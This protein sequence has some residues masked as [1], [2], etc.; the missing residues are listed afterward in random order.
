MYRDNMLVLLETK[1]H[2]VVAAWQELADCV[3]VHLVTHLPTWSTWW[4]GGHDVDGGDD[5][6]EDQNDQ[7]SPDDQHGDHDDHDKVEH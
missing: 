4:T 2:V 3:A 6:D 5:I 7:P 1:H